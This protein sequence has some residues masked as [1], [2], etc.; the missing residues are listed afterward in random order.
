MRFQRGVKRKRTRVVKR[1]RSRQ[2]VGRGFSRKVKKV[3]ES[4]AEKKAVQFQYIGSTSAG[5]VFLTFN[6]GISEGPSS[7]ERT[8]DRIRARSLRIKGYVKGVSGDTDD[9][10]F[11]RIIIGCWKDYSATSP[12]VTDILDDSAF[13]LQSLWDRHALQQKKWIPMYDKIFRTSGVATFAPQ[14]S[15]KLFDLKFSGKRLPMKE[16]VYNSSNQPQNAYFMY[17]VNTYTGL[18]AYPP[19]Q[20]NSRLTYTDF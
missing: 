1:R 10:T 11:W 20:L 3:I 16:H 14:D 7:L 12:V 4:T 19:Y 6:T 2:N 18:P 8:G 13:I 9:V 5:G 17:I 15:F